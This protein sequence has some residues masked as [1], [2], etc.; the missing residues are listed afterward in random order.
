MKFFGSL[1]MV[2]FLIANPI[3]GL[4]PTPD[5]KENPMLNSLLLQALSLQSE[6]LFRMFNNLSEKIRL[7]RAEPP[8]G[9][10]DSLEDLL[11]DYERISALVNTLYNNL[12]AI[13]SSPDM[14]IVVPPL[15]Q[16]FHID[17]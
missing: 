17:L 14:N 7:I 16:I 9:L 4:S 10:D 2:S 6:I 8:I 1:I 11:A 3:F 12:N 15:N 5:N 13:P